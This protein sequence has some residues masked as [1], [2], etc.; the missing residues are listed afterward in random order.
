[1]AT[2]A[3]S[4]GGVKLLLDT[5]H[6]RL[7]AEQLRSDGHDVTA[8]ADDP[9]LASLPDEELLRA[10]SRSGRGLVTENARDFDRIV[11]SWAVTG[12]RH[13]GVVFMSPRRYHRGSSSYPASLVAGLGML[14]ADPPGGDVDWVYWLP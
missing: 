5:H 1:M 2:P 7:A 3:G 14:M 6:S 11:R 12:E 10:A 9:V 13:A 4:A 8:A